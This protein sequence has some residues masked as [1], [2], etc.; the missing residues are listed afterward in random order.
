MTN[1]TVF[2]TITGDATIDRV[3][4]HAQGVDYHAVDCARVNDLHRYTFRLP[5]IEDTTP[6]IAVSVTDGIATGER[7][8]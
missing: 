6:T 2:I 7:L 1:V 5:L 8:G 3:A 4:I